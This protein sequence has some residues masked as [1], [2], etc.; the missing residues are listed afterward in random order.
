MFFQ[1]IFN[2]FLVFRPCIRESLRSTFFQLIFQRFPGFPSLSLFLLRGFV[3]HCF[4]ARGAAAGPA[5]PAP[6]ED[7]GVFL[8]FSTDFQWFPNYVQTIRFRHYPRTP[9]SRQLHK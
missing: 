1:L 6:G 7:I 3:F 9:G 2:V 5:L 4:L 8:W